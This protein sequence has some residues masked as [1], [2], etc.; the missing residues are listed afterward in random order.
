VRHYHQKRHDQKQPAC[1]A[2]HCLASTRRVGARFALALMAASVGGCAV[3]VPIA[4][5]SNVNSATDDDA[6]GSIPD[7]ALKRRL[8]PEDWRRASAA[9]STALDPQGNGSP[10]SW[11]NPGSGARGSFVAT[12]KAYPSDAKICR[13]FR[14]EVESKAPKVMQ[15]VACAGKDGEWAIA[16][17][18]SAAPDGGEKSPASPH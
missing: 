8:D 4:S 9:L 6:T 7:S 1:D 3:S 16:E 11:D 17:I 10:V 13:R 14:T 15:G 12:G 18:A 5:L 2:S